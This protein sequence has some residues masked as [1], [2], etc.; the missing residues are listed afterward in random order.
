MIRAMA[1]VSAAVSIA[2]VLVGACSSSGSS[3]ANKPGIH[4]RAQ[5]GSSDGATIAP[6]PTIPK[7]DYTCKLITKADA[8][9][10]FGVA[11]TSAPDTSDIPLARSTC[12]W[13]GQS[14]PASYAIEVRQFDDPE[15]YSGGAQGWKPLEGLANKAGIHVTPSGGEVIISYV[16][17]GKTVSVSYT[18]HGGDKTAADQ[19]QQFVAMVKQ[20]QAG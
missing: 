17:K 5:N 14:G 10:L 16:D 11:A 19:Q 7:T 8:S 18:V 6:G 3:D 1:R 20:A 2:A 4:A 13:A 15:A 12:D 9:K